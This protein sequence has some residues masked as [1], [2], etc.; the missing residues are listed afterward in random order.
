MSCG[1]EHAV[2][3]G[4]AESVH[5]V[6]P[7]LEDS[8]CRRPGRRRHRGARAILFPGAAENWQG[9][10]CQYDALA[11]GFRHPAGPPTPIMTIPSLGLTAA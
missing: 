9:A 10:G 3:R 8:F 4:D 6:G 7:G 11:A 2:G 1:I 5:V